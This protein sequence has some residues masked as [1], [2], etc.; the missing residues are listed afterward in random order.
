[1]FV[2]VKHLQESRDTMTTIAERQDGHELAVN[3]SSRKS[4][5][6]DLLDATVEAH[7]GLARWKEVSS[8]KIDVSITGAI[9][10]VKG[11]HDVLKDIVMVA[12]TQREHVTT[13]FVGQDRTTSFEPDRVAVQTSDGT[14]LESTDDPEKSFEGQTADSPWGPIHVAYFSGEA[15]WTYLNT[16]FLYLQARFAKEEIDSIEV[17]GE[18][19]RRLK[20]IFPEEVKS[21]TREQIFC[22]G[23]DGLLRRHD[24][25]VDILGGATG[26]NYASDYQEVDGLMFPTKRRVYAYE[27]D[28]QLVPEPLLVAVDITRITLLA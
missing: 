3:E 19:W 12:D 23:P 21:H 4:D 11:Q 8:V 9:W 2:A 10:D 7:G 27:G 17:E 13:S 1:V 15:L 5:V 18:T 24:Y 6:P 22:F 16:P 25:S 28:Y 20:V 14:V 26:L